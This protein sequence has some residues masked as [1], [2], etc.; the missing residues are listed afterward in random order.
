MQQQHLPKVGSLEADAFAPPALL[1]PPPRCACLEARLGHPAPTA[2]PHATADLVCTIRNPCGRCGSGT[3]STTAPLCCATA[4]DATSSSSS[5]SACAI[6]V[7]HEGT[8]RRGRPRLY[9]ATASSLPLPVTGGGLS[10]ES[11]CSALSSPA[12]QIAMAAAGGSSTHELHPGPQQ[13]QP[14]HQY[15]FI[16]SASADCCDTNSTSLLAAAAAAAPSCL[17]AVHT[18]CNSSTSAAAVA[19]SSDS[20]S[21]S[22]RLVSLRRQMEQLLLLPLPDYEE[23]EEDDGCCAVSYPCSAAVRQQQLAAPLCIAKA[24]GCGAVAAAALPA[25]RCSGRAPSA[26]GR[27]GL[28]EGTDIKGHG[29][30]QPCAS[31]PPSIL[32]LKVRQ[33]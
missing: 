29:H 8:M 31:G 28:S 1:P 25:A 3:S 19:N 10:L 21:S 7:N 13:P 27:R 14:H 4:T 23:E 24:A 11:L 12:S 16:H 5:S 32:Q 20:S 26:T 17:S 2:R 33:A 6:D 9:H 30:A 22:S 15:S 18:S